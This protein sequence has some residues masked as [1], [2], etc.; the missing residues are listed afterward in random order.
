MPSSVFLGFV[1]CVTNA[2]RLGGKEANGK[3]ASAKQSSTEI[4]SSTDFDIQV[5]WIL[6]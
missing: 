5:M 2:G 6:R 4:F 3:L 1:G